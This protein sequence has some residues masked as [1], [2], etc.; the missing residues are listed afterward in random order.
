MI[1]HLQQCQTYLDSLE[2]RTLL[3]ATSTDDVNPQPSPSQGLSSQ[4]PPFQPRTGKNIWSGQNPNPNLMINRRGP[5]KRNRD[6]T[7]KSMPPPPPSASR[8][9]PAPSLATHLLSRDPAA[10][11]TA[12]QQ[13]FLSHAGCGTLSA[14]AL[15]QW[16]AQD[17]HFSRGYISFV[18][19]LIGKVRLPQATNMQNH[20]LCRT[21]DLLIGALNNFRREMTF[22]EVTA[23][24]YSLHVPIEPPDPITKSYLDLFVASSS[25]SVSLLEGMVVLWATEHVRIPTTR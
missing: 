2:G 19:S 21:M 9:A 7:S 6:G 3:H 25:P 22:F 10:F 1:E 23:T 20:P 4:T 13:T 17:S 14:G 8:P 11:T 24:K 15:S 16:L 18:G 12:T 5:N